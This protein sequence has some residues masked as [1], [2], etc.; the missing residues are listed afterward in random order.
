M[1]EEIQGKAFKLAPI[2]VLAE[3]YLKGLEL[4]KHLPGPER[5]LI[6]QENKRMLDAF[7]MFQAWLHPLG[8]HGSALVWQVRFPK[9]S[10]WEDGPPVCGSLA[11]VHAAY[12]VNKRFAG[13]M[14]LAQGT[15][16]AV[17][18]TEK[19]LDQALRNKRKSAEEHEAEGIQLAKEVVKN[20]IEIRREKGGA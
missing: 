5:A 19:I 10:R 16:V 15:G 12:R 18:D 20:E 9:N 14:E 6:V 1:K 17:L 8:F 7:E 3:D 13:F 11:A 2:P 4:A